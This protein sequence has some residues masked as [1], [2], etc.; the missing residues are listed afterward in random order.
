ML[1]WVLIKRKCKSEQNLQQ[2]WKIRIGCKE[3]I[4]NLKKKRENKRKRNKK[5]DRKKKIDAEKK[6]KEKGKRK[7]GKRR[8]N[9]AIDIEIV[10]LI[11]LNREKDQDLA[12]EKIEKIKSTDIGAQAK[13]DIIDSSKN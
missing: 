2:Q 10:D 12:G 4:F 3:P 9:T 5:I 13:N 7:R 6:R 8:E 11:L 1:V